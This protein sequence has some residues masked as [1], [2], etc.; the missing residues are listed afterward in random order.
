MSQERPIIIDG[1]RGVG[2]N[3]DLGDMWEAMFEPPAKTNPDNPGQTQDTSL[4]Q[5]EVE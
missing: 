2:W 1:S 5:P 3:R 4:P